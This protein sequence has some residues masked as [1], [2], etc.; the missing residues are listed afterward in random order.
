VQTLP[1]PGLLPQPS[2]HPSVLPPPGVL[3]HT[4]APVPQGLCTCHSFHLHTSPP[5]LPGQLSLI[6]GSCPQ[7]SHPVH[8]PHFGCHGSQHLPSN[9]L[10][11]CNGD[12][13]CPQTLRTR[14]GINTSCLWLCP[15][16]CHLAL[17]LSKQH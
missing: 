5:S 2:T 3:P 17:Q 4:Q 6:F 12:S 14:A 8:I 15:G 16:A 1:L 9:P 10:H 11:L 7:V 13:S